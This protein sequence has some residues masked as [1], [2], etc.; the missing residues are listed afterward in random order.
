MSELYWLS[1]EQMTWL[2]PHFPNSRGKPR[3]ITDGC[4]NNH[5]LTHRTVA[6]IVACTVATSPIT[7]ARQGSLRGRDTMMEGL[8][9]ASADPKSVMIDGFRREIGDH[10]PVIGT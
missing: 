7:R 5:H 9:A 10:L 2:Q 6:N 3:S 1:D 8:A 4:G